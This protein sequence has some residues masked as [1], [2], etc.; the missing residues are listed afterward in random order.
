MK[1]FLFFMIP[2]FC[3]RL[4]AEAVKTGAEARRQAI[5]STGVA[6]LRWAWKW[7]S[8]RSLCAC[9]DSRIPNDCRI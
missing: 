1:N 3:N 2:K 5:F 7:W 9:F 8:Q 4:S 6:E